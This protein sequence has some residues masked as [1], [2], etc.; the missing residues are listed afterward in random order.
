MIFL[1]TMGE[2]SKATQ[3]DA[4]PNMHRFEDN[5]ITGS[6]I[7]TNK[8]IVHLMD[9]RVGVRPW[10]SPRLLPVQDENK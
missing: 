10:S 8:L 1:I 3:W 9:A 2:H 5:V 7:I 4:V 6:V